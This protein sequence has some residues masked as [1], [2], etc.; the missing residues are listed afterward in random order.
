MQLCGDLKVTTAA[1]THHVLTY[2]CPLQQVTF[3]ISDPAVYTDLLYLVALQQRL[4][5]PLATSPMQGISE[6]E[7]VCH[8]GRGVIAAHGLQTPNHTSRNTLWHSMRLRNLSLSQRNCT[9]HCICRT[10]SLKICIKLHV[11]TPRDVCLPLRL[12]QSSRKQSYR[13]ANGNAP[14]VMKT[15]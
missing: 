5:P 8:L 11:N 4:L 7:P 13:T 10:A 15:P 9:T 2:R 3:N 14:R 12:Q 6:I 1:L